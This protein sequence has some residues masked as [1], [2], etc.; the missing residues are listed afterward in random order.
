MQADP[1]IG[2]LVGDYLLQNDAMATRKK[3]SSWWC[4]LH[5]ALWTLSVAVFA[6]WWSNPT[7][8]AI[9]F[10][11]H[12]AQDRTQF[13]AWWMNK[14]GQQGFAKP[15]LAPWSVIVVDNVL[16]LVVLW[17]VSALVR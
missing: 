8:L 13:V 4:G 5:C 12:F 1:I 16:H 9:L 17:V 10:A 6:G 15:P 14:M 2:H 7:A 11:T 3:Q